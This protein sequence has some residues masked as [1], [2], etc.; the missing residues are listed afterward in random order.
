MVAQSKNWCITWNNYPANWKALLKKVLGARDKQP[1][2]TYWIA[3][4][5]IAPQTGTPHLQMFIQLT[6]RLALTTLKRALQKAQILPAPHLEAAKGDLEQ[7]KTY[8]KKEGNWEESGNER[9]FNPKKAGASSQREDLLALRDAIMGDKND[10]DLATHQ[11]TALAFARYPRFVEALRQGLKEKE[12]KEREKTRMTDVV[13]REW[14]N[15]A[16]LDLDECVLPPVQL[17]WCPNITGSHF[18]EFDYFETHE[19]TFS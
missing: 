7:N 8:C 11:D 2:I 14:Q 19:Y 1:L 17:T 10:V 3:G 18:K 9:E 5:E 16:V 6:K 13:L 12:T 15:Q 4:K